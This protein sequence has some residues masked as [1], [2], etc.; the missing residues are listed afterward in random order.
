M[1]DNDPHILRYFPLYAAILPWVVVGGLQF[2]RIEGA[3]QQ[4]FPWALSLLTL[5]A[6]VLLFSAGHSLVK[7]VRWIEAR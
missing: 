5:G 6:S 3:L 4:G 2:D 1:P 7:I